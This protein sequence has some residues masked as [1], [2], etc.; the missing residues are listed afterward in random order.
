MTDG[1]VEVAS[2]SDAAQLAAERVDRLLA[3]LSA[4]DPRSAAVA[5]ELTCCLVQ[6]YGAGLARI[7]D[8]IGDERSAELCTD[9]LVESLLLVHDLHPL[10]A[11][12]RIR[13][14][15]RVYPGEL[16]YRGI[17]ATG[18]V[19]LC[20]TGGGCGSVRRAAVDR[21]EA[22]VR[23]AAPEVAGVEVDSPPPPLPLL[24]VSR[25]PDTTVRSGPRVPNGVAP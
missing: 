4:A 18:V 20:L 2:G 13:R 21:I 8:M 19:R 7:V 14:A 15:L 6:L 5:E 11:D 9:P 16:E 17:D 3:Q 12:T 24:Q 23:Q 22:I 1:L 25:R 10:D